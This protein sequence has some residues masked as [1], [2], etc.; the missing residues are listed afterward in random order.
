ML[1][2]SNFNLPYVFNDINLANFNIRTR[3]LNVILFYA[4]GSP[5]AY[6]SG[7]LLDS[8]ILSRRVRTRIAIITL[9]ILFMA[10]WGGTYAWQRHITRQ[11]ASSPDFKRID[12]TSSQYIGPIFLFIAFGFVHWLFQNTIYW[13]LGA[14]ADNSETAAPA[15]FAGFFKSLQGVGS[16]CAWRVSNEELPF[17]VDLAVTWGLVMGSL[18]IAAPVLMGRIKN[19][20]INKKDESQDHGLDPLDGVLPLHSGAGAKPVGSA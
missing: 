11:E 1:F 18:L 13:F 6:L 15:D 5:G 20:V 7:Y 3:A 9:C 19:E 8:N 17:L 10:M 4:A 16:A 12:C 14:L 2:V